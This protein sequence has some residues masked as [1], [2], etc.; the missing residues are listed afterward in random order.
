MMGLTDS[1][2][3]PTID[4]V[5]TNGYILLGYCSAERL[6]II[7]TAIYLSA[8]RHHDCYLSVLHNYDL[9]CPKGLF[10]STVSY[11]KCHRCPQH[12]VPNPVRTSCTCE[13]GFYALT[14]LVPCKRE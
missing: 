1:L 2:K 6:F 10:K 13:Y 4:I 12:S 8:S 7:E 3:C 14:P 9:E 11:A 5:L